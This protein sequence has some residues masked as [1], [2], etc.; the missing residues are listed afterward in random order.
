M[1]LRFKFSFG[2]TSTLKDMPDIELP[3]ATSSLS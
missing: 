1:R 3:E 2:V